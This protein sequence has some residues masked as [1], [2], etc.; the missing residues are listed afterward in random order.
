[1]TVR[2][3]TEPFDLGE[4]AARLTAGRTDVGAMVTFSGLCRGRTDGET[5]AA[6]TLECYEAMAV[7]E[8]SRIEDE[9]RSRWP[10]DDV[11]I[12]HR[13]GRM[14][15][16]DPIVLVITLSAH[17][18]AAFEA[19]EFLMDYLKTSAPFWKKEEDGRE[20]RWVE[21]KAEDD[22]HAARWATM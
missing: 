7:A 21:A 3:Q 8:L 15:P 20:A 16:G 12:V 17:R 5:I 14:L 22:A 19:A 10:L 6:M 13:H 2:V 4:E 11:L 18:K 9:A 1:M